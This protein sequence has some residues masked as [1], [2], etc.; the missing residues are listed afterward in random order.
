MPRIR[1]PPSSDFP[2]DRLAVQTVQATGEPRRASRDPLMFFRVIAEIERER[3]LP[4]H[5][6]SPTKH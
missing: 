2:G 1:K 4:V 3:G 6:E 5:P